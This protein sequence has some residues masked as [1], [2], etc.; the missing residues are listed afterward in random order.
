MRQTPAIRNLKSSTMAGL[1]VLSV[2]LPTVT[3]RTG[4]AAEAPKPACVINFIGHEMSAEKTRVILHAN[5]AIDYRGGTLRGNQVVLDLANV[6]VALPSTVVEMGSPEVDRLV[7][8]PEISRDGEHLLKIRLLGVRAASHKVESKGNELYVD[9]TPMKGARDGEKG[10][11]KVINNSS[12]IM[13]SIRGSRPAE[14]KWAKAVPVNDGG[15]AGA[16]DTAPVDRKAQTSGRQ[17]ARN[18]VAV[19]AGEPVVTSVLRAEPVIVA[20]RTP[21]AAPNSGSSGPAAPSVESDNA[22][23]AEALN[24]P[25]PASTMPAASAKPAASAPSPVVVAAA[26]PLAATP[27]PLAATAGIDEARILK[28]LVGRS[29]TLETGTQIARVSVS[30]PA[31]AEPVAISPTQLLINGLAP[32]V[33]S[34]VLWPKQGPAVVYELVVQIDTMALAQQLQTIFPKENVRVQSSKDSII[35]TGPIS[36][37][38][39]GDKMVKLASDYSAKVVND[40]SAPGLQRKQ[41]MLKVKFAEVSK[42]AM[43]ELATMWTH[44]DPQHPAGNDRGNSG[45]GQF[46]P[47]FGNVINNPPGPDITWSDAINLSYFDKRINLGMFITALK[48]RGLFQELAEPTLMAASGQ[49]ASFLAGGEFPVPIAQ[50]GANF[51]SLTVEWKKFG[52][53][54]DFK[55]TINADGMISMKVKPEVSSLDFS[56]GVQIQGFKIPSLIVRRAETEVELRDGQS[57]AIAGLYDRSLASTRQKIPILGDIPILG[58]LFR[59]KAIEK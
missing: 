57:F 51:V 26:A 35:L 28:V 29:L 47:S 4:R 17:D 39:V 3:P 54:L 46:T 14:I 20:D 44:V 45:T 49:D 38:A 19:P 21:A 27:G 15:P 10:L 55:P 1:L 13:A 7:V 2:A 52:I 56:N 22:P 58:Y 16:A 5:T 42:Q 37:A 48:S 31:V 30:N 33:V 24:R 11:P 12:E 25:A 18:L 9:L 34:L 40:L 36:E 32:G 8:G 43:T 23:A 41:I 59:S 6:E 53:M 50:P